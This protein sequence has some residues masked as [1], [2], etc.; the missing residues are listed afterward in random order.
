MKAIQIKKYSKDINVEV[1]NIP[2]PNIS[3]NEILIKVK[4]AAVNPLE[5]LTLTGS[6]RLIQDYKMPLTLGNECSGIVENIGKNVTD[7]KVGDKVYTRLPISKIGAFAEYVAVDS[8]FVSVMPKDYDFITSAAIPLTAL[9]AYQAFTEELEAKQGETVLITGGPGSFGELA[10]PIAKYLGLNVI[11]S[12]NERLKEHFI[13]LGTDKY[14]SYNKEN[15]SELV[16]NV[17]YVID[18]LGANEFDK[19]L[20]VLKKGGRLLSLRTSP[21]KKFAENNNFSFIKKLLFSLAG[22]KYDKKAMKD[23]KEYRFMFVRADGEE[24]RKITKIVEDKNIKPKIYS[25]VFNIDNASEALRTV[26]KKHT[27]GKIIISM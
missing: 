3:D 21:N 4:A 24:L 23:E 14:I 27:N 6:V 9:T 18:T 26:I 1:A 2:I 5:I 12:G 8:K 25:T 16:S 7:F 10:V 22:S 15:Y 17:D 19:E 13:D 20:S 11:V